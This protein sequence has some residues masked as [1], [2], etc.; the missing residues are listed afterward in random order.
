MQATAPCINN[1]LESPSLG[2]DVVG[3]VL[4]PVEE[5]DRATKWGPRGLES[6]RPLLELSRGLESRL[7]PKEGAKIG[8]GA[9]AESGDSRSPGI[10]VGAEEE[11]SLKENPSHVIE[12]DLGARGVMENA[13]PDPRIAKGLIL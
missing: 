9:A 12:V 6:M 8:L 1:S 3:V 10:E 5:E 2:G 13:D 7:D 11:A 4:A